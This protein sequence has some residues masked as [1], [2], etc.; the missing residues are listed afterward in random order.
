MTPERFPRLVDGDEVVGDVTASGGRR[1]R[2]PAGTPVTG[3]TV[4]GAAAAL[5][6]G[7]RRRGQAAEM[8]GTSTVL[9]LPS[10]RPRSEPAFV[11]M[12]HAARGRWLLLGRDGRDAAGACA[13]SATCSA[14]S[15]FDALTADGGAA[16][17]RART[18][19]SS[20]RT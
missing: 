18:G 13:G 6:A 2:A 3:G 11:A 12:R 9:I 15:S 19:S 16:S 7:A 1:D 4:D 20:C 10:A 14:A 17:R 8:T 5:E